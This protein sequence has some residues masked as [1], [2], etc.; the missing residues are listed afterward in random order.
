MW[1]DLSLSIQDVE[2]FPNPKK[3]WEQFRGLRGR[4]T[5]LF[6]TFILKLV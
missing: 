6:Y 4:S 5:S 3:V 2:K 1:P